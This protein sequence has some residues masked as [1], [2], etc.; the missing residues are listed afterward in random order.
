MSMPERV[1][2][3]WRSASCLGQLARVGDRSGPGVDPGGGG[4]R[5]LLLHQVVVLPGHVVGG[6]L[7]LDILRAR[8]QVLV[9]RLLG[10]ALACRSAWPKVD[11]AE[12]TEV[13]TF[14]A[15]STLEPQPAALA[16]V[17]AA[18]TPAGVGRGGGGRRGG[19]GGQLRR[20][21][22]GGLGGRGGGGRPR[23]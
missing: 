21:A 7:A 14:S 22:G 9:A 18:A 17:E 2:A 5:E 6:L 15:P 19:G 20:G 3:I 16:P 23:R 10:R 13:P 12:T 11:R 8:L 1:M 4:H